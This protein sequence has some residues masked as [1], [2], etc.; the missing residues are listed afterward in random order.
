M[1]EIGLGIL[2][3]MAAAGITLG[4]SDGLVPFPLGSGVIVTLAISAL[5]LMLRGWYRLSLKRGKHSRHRVRSTGLAF[6]VAGL[7][8]VIALT[9]PALSE[10]A[11]LISVGGFPIGTYILGQGIFILFAILL[12]LFAG[13]QRRID[14]AGDP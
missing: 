6:A 7:A 14:A 9:L 3:I 5:A 8:I 4:L 2:A 13:W 11:N 10:T 1:I 12:F